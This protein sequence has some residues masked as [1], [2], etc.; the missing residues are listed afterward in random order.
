MRL[1]G[2]VAIITGGARGIGRAY[3]LAL[4]KKGAQIV[5][6]DILDSVEVKR[7]IEM[8]GGEALSLYTDVSN[9]A[10][11]NEMVHKTIDRFGRVDILI[12]NAAVFADLGKKPFY[13]ISVKEWD[14]VID[15]NLKGCFLCCKAVYPQMKKQGKGKIVNISS[16]TF[17]SGSPFFI[18]YVASKGA[19]IGFTRAL[20]RELGSD[21]INVNAVAP[22]LTVSEA[23]L[24]NPMFPEKEI[25]SAANARCL[26]RDEQPADLIGTILFLASEESDFVTGQTIVVDGGLIFH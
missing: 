10:S 16:G 6:S 3:A 13:Q 15:V 19:I 20:A 18:H 1:N 14:D 22:G 21:G 2:K 4:S 25:K 8:A 23:V 26:K 9:E 17:F 5:V 12:N 11:T 7:E 24:G